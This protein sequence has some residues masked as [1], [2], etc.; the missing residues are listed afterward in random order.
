M[1]RTPPRDSGIG[2]DRQF[3]PDVHDDNDDNVS[4]H[5]NDSESEVSDPEDDPPQP[6][7]MAAP[8]AGAAAPDAPQGSQI[9]QLPIFSGAPELDVEVWILQAEGVQ[10]MFGWTDAQTAAAA[11]IRLSA[12]A[13]YW[14][15]A[16]HLS[17]KHYLAWTG[18]EGL[19]L[20]L[21]AR[22]RVQINALAAVDAVSKLSQLTGE[23]VGKFYD[24]C[25]ITLNKKN[26]TYTDVQKDTAAYRNQFAVDMFVFFSAGLLPRLKSRATGGA[27]A[28]QNVEDLKKAA[29]DAE[30]YFSKSKSGELMEIEDE[31]HHGKV[32]KSPSLVTGAQGVEPGAMEEKMAKLEAELAA[33]KM[34]RANPNVKCYNCQGQGHISRVCPS[35]RKPYDG[36]SRGGGNASGSR[37]FG[38]RGGWRGNRGRGAGGR[39]GPKKTDDKGLYMVDDEEA[40]N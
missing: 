18:A 9:N 26:Y 25:V 35:P 15:Q 14:L 17:G 10:R 11:K 33:I 32:E 8:N 23:S 34:V 24:R 16:C 36:A 5:D 3:L 4:N 38:G 6:V 20:G 21:L 1:Q 13:A 27:N 39:G 31:E 29:L 40:E 37:G 12:E 19:K 28:P 2:A 7:I 30:L 22:F